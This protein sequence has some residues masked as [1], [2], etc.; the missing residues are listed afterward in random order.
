[1]EKTISKNFSELMLIATFALVITSCRKEQNASIEGSLSDANA[2]NC[3]FYLCPYPDSLQV[4]EGNKFLL[5]TFAKG[6]QIY[7]VKRSATDPNV[8]SWVNI[9]PLATLYA[10]PDFVNPVINHF[11]GPSW[12]FIKGRRKARRV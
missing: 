2:T 7:Q 11:A 6:V 10:R 1:M 9:A 12:E 5:Q 3:H 8:F 4:P